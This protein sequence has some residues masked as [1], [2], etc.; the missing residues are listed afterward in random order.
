MAQP[1]PYAAAMRYL[2]AVWC[3]VVG[4]RPAPRR[5]ADH[6]SLSHVLED[7]SGPLTA[8]LT[9][10]A[11]LS[12]DLALPL[13]QRQR[14]QLLERNGL[15][16]HA[17]LENLRCAIAVGE[18][19]FA[20]HPRSVRID[21]LVREVIAVMRPLH[22]ARKQRLE[23]ILPDETVRVWADPRGMAHSIINLL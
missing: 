5:P 16:L 6:R 20:I 12:R 21:D 18:G 13:K 14:L 7:R 2:D 15:G 3:S 10:A 11:L 17:R 22:E 23:L 4:G 9:S 1:L 8:R 19:S